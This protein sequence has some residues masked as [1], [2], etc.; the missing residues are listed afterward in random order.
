MLSS[1]SFYPLGSYINNSTLA[2]MSVGTYCFTRLPSWTQ[3]PLRSLKKAFSINYYRIITTQKH[4]VVSLNEHSNFSPFLLAL[5]E[6]PVVLVY[7]CPPNKT[8]THT[9]MLPL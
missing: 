6:A 5:Q 1:G 8:H 9:L 4:P 7:P 3:G 2:V